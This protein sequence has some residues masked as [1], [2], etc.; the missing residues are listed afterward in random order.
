MMQWNTQT[1]NI[2][3]N[4]KVKIYFTLIALSKTNVVT[5]NFHADDSAKGR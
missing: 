3:T 5:W 2:K 1:G 4:L